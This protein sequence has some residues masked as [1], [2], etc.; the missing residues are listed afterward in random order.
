MAPILQSESV[1]KPGNTPRRWHLWGESSGDQWFPGTKGK[2]RGNFPSWW[3]YHDVLD[4]ACQR[5]IYILPLTW[6]YNC[7]NQARLLYFMWHANEISFLQNYLVSHS[8]CNIIHS[9]NCWNTCNNAIAE[10][11]CVFGE[12]IVAIC[13][14]RINNIVV[15]RSI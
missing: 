9:I 6:W 11:V 2:Y 12:Y 15:P 7:R 4:I 3:R 1:P 10:Q 13:G 8:I 14:I 5:R